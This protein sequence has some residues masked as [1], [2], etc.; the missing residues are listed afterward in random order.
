MVVVVKDQGP[1]ANG[2][3]ELHSLTPILAILQEKGYKVALVTDGR[4]SGASGKIPAAI[5]LFPEAAE[6]GA[7]GK[8]QDGDIVELDGENGVLKTN[9]NLAQSTLE[10]DTAASYQTGFGRDLFSVLR[11][12]AACAEKGGGINS[13]EKLDRSG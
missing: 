6:G 12:N 2:M 7:I 8:I 10:K 1:K 9:S 5:H 13:L 3:P 4:M 11:K